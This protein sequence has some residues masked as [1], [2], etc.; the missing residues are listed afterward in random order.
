[1]TYGGLVCARCGLRAGSSVVS[2]SAVAA[3]VHCVASASGTR[4]VGHS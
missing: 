1:V 2:G 4:T 3:E